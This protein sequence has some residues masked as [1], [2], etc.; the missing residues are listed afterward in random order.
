MPINVDGID[1]GMLSV[2]E[3]VLAA[4]DPEEASAVRLG[5]LGVEL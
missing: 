2:C 1:S 5:R 4:W 3:W